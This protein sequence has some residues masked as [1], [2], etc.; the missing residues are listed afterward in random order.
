MAVRGQ[1]LGDFPV[2]GQRAGRV[3]R[4]RRRVPG[5]PAGRPSS[6]RAQRESGRPTTSSSR[7]PFWNPMIPGFRPFRKRWPMRS[8]LSPRAIRTVQTINSDTR[9]VG[10]LRHSARMNRRHGTAGHSG[11]DPMPY[12]KKSTIEDGSKAVKRAHTDPSSERQQKARADRWLPL[13]IAEFDSSAPSAIDDCNFRFKSIIIVKR[14]RTIGTG[15]DGPLSWRA[16]GIEKT[17][18]RRP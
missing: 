11:T 16:A 14:L 17:R 1:A 7:L 2:A 9:A 10:R 5:G 8:E 12:S 18:I 4:G 15:A 13:A 3:R 6:G